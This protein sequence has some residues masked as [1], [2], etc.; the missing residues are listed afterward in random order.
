M[1][2]ALWR[3]RAGLPPPLPLK[4]LPSDFCSDLFE[5]LIAL[6][7]SL[8]PKSSPRTARCCEHPSLIKEWDL[9]G[10]RTSEP[11]P[12]AASLLQTEHLS[13]HWSTPN[14]RS[15]YTGVTTAVLHYNR[16]RLSQLNDIYNC[17]CPCTCRL[18]LYESES[19]GKCVKFP[20]HSLLVVLMYTWCGSSVSVTLLIQ[21][22]HVYSDQTL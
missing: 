10:G 19:R 12:S 21:Y 16:Y 15:T 4:T 3:Q 17:V 11:S 8:C 7:W 14:L 13:S 5:H 18:T 6:S 20:P 1:F 9:T 2:L 22:L